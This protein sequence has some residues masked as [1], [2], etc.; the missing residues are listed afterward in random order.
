MMNR[1][2]LL[3][4]AISIIGEMQDSYTAPKNRLSN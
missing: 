2:R 4:R 1:D 3:S